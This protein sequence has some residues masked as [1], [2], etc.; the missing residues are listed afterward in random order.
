ML[1][2]AP[3]A[4]RTF[5]LKGLRNALQATIDHMSVFSRLL[6]PWNRL[7]RLTIQGS[8]TCS[9]D[10]LVAIVSGC[11]ESLTLLVLRKP[12]V[13]RADLASAVRQLVTLR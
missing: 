11:S 5:H 13:F 4:Y 2:T 7:E 6:S 1:Q 10:E 12:L 8:W 9:D 3:H